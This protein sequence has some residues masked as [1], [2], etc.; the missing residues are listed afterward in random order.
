MNVLILNGSA[1]GE[2]GVTG[3]LLKSFVEGLIDGNATVTEFNV[4]GLKISPCTACLS[5]MHKVLGECTIKD[6]MEEIY[7][8]MKRSD[9]MVLAT[10]VYTDNMSAQLKSIM[11]RSI[12]CMQ[13]FLIKDRFGRVRHP[14][15]WRMPEKFM[16]IS[17]SGFPEM[18]TF[19]PLIATYRAQALNFASEA[20]A[21]ICVPGSIAIQMEPERLDHHLGLIREAGKEIALKGSIHPDLLRD[22]NTPPLTIDEYF[23]AA[24]KYESWLRKKLGEIGLK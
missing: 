21:E 18:E 5:C 23:S 20:I 7:R 10:P 12:C 3:R 6:D 22:L 15:T 14:H 4:A 16:L 2:K 19:E 9:I 1:R 11:D 24:A 13:G 17:T 8:S